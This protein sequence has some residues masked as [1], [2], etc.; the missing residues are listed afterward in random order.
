MHAADVHMKDF[1]TKRA[2]PVRHHEKLV[3]YFLESG[4]KFMKHDR[5][6]DG[7]EVGRKRY[8]QLRI[9][10]TRYP[11]AGTI[12]ASDRRESYF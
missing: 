9:Q 4:T 12:T 10:E 2:I 5:D 8:P 6:L 7:G 3:K 1:A 11:R